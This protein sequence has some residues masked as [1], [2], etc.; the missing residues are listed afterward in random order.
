LTPSP[1][2]PG[3]EG[4]CGQGSKP[5]FRS[6]RPSPFGRGVGGEVTPNSPN[7]MTRYI[8]VRLGQSVVLLFIVSVVTFA[9]I[10]SAP[11][12]PAILLNPELT[13]ADAERIV[14]EMGLNDP[15]PVQYGRWIGN[16]F[17]GNL[18]NSY[19]QLRP[20]SQLIVERLPNSLLLTAAGLLIALLLAIP[21]G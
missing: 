1:P 13:K 20:V 16:V 2:L 18:G 12:G 15:L 9:L 19:S 8:T 21:A 3:R 11:G 10:H 5:M 7:T 6:K 4:E 14:Q 17:Q